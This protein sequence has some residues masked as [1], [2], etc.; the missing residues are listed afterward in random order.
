MKEGISRRGLLIGGTIAT[1]AAGAGLIEMRW[2]RREQNPLN[3]THAWST[4]VPQT[5]EEVDA[6]MAASMV[7]LAWV[8]ADGAT[9]LN[10]HGGIFYDQKSGDLSIKSIGHLISPP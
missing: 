1:A 7:R 9:E 6:I 8:G 4:E 10:G 3:A 5:P 2:G